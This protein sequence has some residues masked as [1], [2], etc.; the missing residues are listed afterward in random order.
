[1]RCQCVGPTIPDSCD[2]VISADAY[3]AS[4]AVLNNDAKVT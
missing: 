2:V 1:V 4:S 3:Q